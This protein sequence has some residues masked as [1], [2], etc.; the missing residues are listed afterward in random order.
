MHKNLHD[1]NI[2][3]KD[4]H[5]KIG[6]F[7]YPLLGFS[8]DS[9]GPCI[10]PEGFK[11]SQSDVYSLGILFMQIVTSITEKHVL[12]QIVNAFMKETA[13]KEHVP[14]VMQDHI[15]LQTIQLCLKSNPRSR[16]SITSICEHIKNLKERP[17]YISYRALHQE[18]SYIVAIAMAI[19][20][21]QG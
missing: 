10:P 6:D 9:V 18:V 3:I 5:A 14:C 2:L 19:T 13:F 16:P 15:L 7:Y 20:K 21:S 17:E 12:L 4:D 11:S 1:C 8:Q